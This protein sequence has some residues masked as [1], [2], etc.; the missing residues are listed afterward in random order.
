[1]SALSENEAINYTPQAYLLLE[2]QATV[3][4][5]YHQGQ[6]IAMSGAS[7]THNR[8]VSRLH[9]ALANGLAGKPCEAFMSD[10]RVEINQG[11]NY[12]YPDITVVC[13]E[14]QLAS[15]R[16]DTITNPTIVIEVLSASTEPQDRGHKFRAYEQLASLTEYILVDQY[17]VRVEYF[18][19]VSA[20]EW[21]LLVLTDLTET[22]QLQ[23]I[24]VTISLANIYRG[25][26]FE[27]PKSPTPFRRKSDSKRVRKNT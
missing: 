6:I 22:F 8:L 1:M 16:N 4:S 27:L 18:R 2:E 17:R 20:Q 7:L 10:L 24:A 21:Q 9:V 13:G 3:K 14:P 26:T 11:R 15:Q 25:I 12:F 5:E 23:S 19:R